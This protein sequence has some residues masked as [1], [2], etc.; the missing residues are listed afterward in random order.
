MDRAF[1][2]NFYYNGKF[3]YLEVTVKDGVIESIKKDAGNIARS[4]LPGAVL[5]AATD[6]HVHFRTP[7]ETDK[8]DFS[9]GS[10][11]AIFGGTTLVMD[12]PNNII[13]IKDYNAFSDKLGVI[14]GTSYSDF[15]LY[16]MET[17]SNSLIVD[18]RSIGLKVY[19]GGS[20]NAAG[21]MAIPDQEAEMINEKGFTV[22]FHG[23]LEECLRK[24]Q[25][26]TKNLREHNLSRPIECEL[27]A[28][29]YVGSLNLKSKI[30]AH[31][32]SPEVSGDFLREVTPHHLLLNDEMPLGSIGKV[33]PPLRDRNTQ[34][35][36]LYAYISGQFD[37]LSSDHAPHTEK[38][39]AEFEYAKS[40]II[41]VETRI[42]LMLALVKKKI[43]FL[44]VLYKTGIERP[45]SIFGIRKGKIEVGYDADFMCVDF[46]N[47]KKVNEDRLHS[48]L[49]RS[50]FNGMDAIFPSHVV[51]RGEVVIDNYEEIS[52][53]L[54]RF[55]PKGYY[56]QKL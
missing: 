56:D 27:A 4:Y 38:D 33:N 36:L 8:E 42:P 7:G 48:K 41:G 51:M 14:N 3:D 16:S 52:D 43:L 50:P 13:P 37:I 19:L 34:E 10:L 25:S 40:G 29:G 28:A 49:P 20:T 12:M 22:I 18:S 5:P 11:S 31:V 35:R 32:S 46:T 53:P 17:G 9:T 24:H 6:I 26:E 21:T 15:A 2:G 44:D 30:M 47:E 55:V 45:P 54:G 23:E 1:C 39:K